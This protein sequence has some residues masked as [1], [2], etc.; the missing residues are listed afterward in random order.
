LSNSEYFAFTPCV[1]IIEP[2]QNWSEEGKR[3]RKKDKEEYEGREKEMKF[4]N[5]D[6][7]LNTQQT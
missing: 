2:T 7:S 5:E 4:R 6:A 3:R 1:N